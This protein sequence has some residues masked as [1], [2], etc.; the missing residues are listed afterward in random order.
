MPT[1]RFGSRGIYVELLQSTLKKLG[2]YFGEVDG[3]F[4]SQTRDA[5][6]RFQREFGLVV[7]GIVGTRT[8]EKLMPYI[9]G[10]VGRIVPTDMTY[11]YRILIMNLEALQRKYPFL[12]TFYYGE[13]VLGKRLPYIKLGNGSNTVF[14][15]ASIHANEWINSV[16]FMK[17]VEDFCEA[18]VNN[19]NLRGYN[20]REIFENSTIYLAPML[21]PDGIDLVTG[22]ISQSL[23]AYRDAVEISRDYP[24]IPFP[25]GWKANIRGVDL[26]LQFPAEWEEAR[27]VKFAQGFT[28]PAPRDFVG[29]GPLTEPEALSAYNFTLENDFR[30][31][32]TYHTQGE[33]IFWRYLNYEPEEAERIGQQFANVSGYQLINEVETNSYAGYRDWFIST[34]RRPG[35]TVETGSGVNPLPISQFNKIYED[36]IEI[37]LLGALL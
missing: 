15:S 5:V 24:S 16:V 13:S 2:F 12:E 21:N 32:L 11:S 35:Y 31:I 7:D 9:N 30:L 6:Y 18:Y 28:S 34:Y 19:Q 4:G 14:Y 23:P 33:V 8:W 3:I 17:F 1:L 29:F 27:R 36:N 22:V 20:V 26:N 10:T 37:L 25:S